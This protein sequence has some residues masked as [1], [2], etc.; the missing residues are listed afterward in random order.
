MDDGASDNSGY[1]FSVDCFERCDIEKLTKMLKDKYNIETSININQNKIIHVKANSAK[2]FK[3]LIEP[4][5]CDCMR[6]KLQIYK[7]DHKN[8]VVNRVDLEQSS[9]NGENCWEALVGNQQPS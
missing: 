1:K 4:Y 3:E 8:K 9:L 7:Y 6:Y 2:R 5:M